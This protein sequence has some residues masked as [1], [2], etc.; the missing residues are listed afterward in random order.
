M[1]AADVR[2]A[3]AE[4]DRRIAELESALE[5]KAVLVRHNDAY[6][7][8]SATG[9]LTGGPYCSR[10]WEADHR[11]RHLTRGLGSGTTTHCPTCKSNY[12]WDTTT[13]MK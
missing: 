10:C 9:K 1:E 3:M 13:W 12:K 4:K 11:A 8:A 7:Q 6:Y 2:E 5:L